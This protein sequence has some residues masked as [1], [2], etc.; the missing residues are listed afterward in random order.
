MVDPDRCDLHEVAI[1]NG[2]EESEDLLRLAR[3]PIG[4]ECQLCAVCRDARVYVERRLAEEAGQVLTPDQNADAAWR[5]LQSAIASAKA[6]VH[7]TG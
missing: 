6:S 3:S 1:D 2:L 7:R 5:K 4:D